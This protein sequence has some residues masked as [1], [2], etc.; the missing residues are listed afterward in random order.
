[1]EE[2]S[3]QGRGINKGGGD[4]TLYKRWGALTGRRRRWMKWAQQDEKEW[5]RIITWQQH[6][7]GDWTFLPTACGAVL[8]SNFDSGNNITWSCSAA[9]ALGCV[10]ACTCGK[11]Q[12]CRGFLLDHKLQTVAHSTPYRVA[13]VVVTRIS[14][15][16]TAV[17]PSVCCIGP[18]TASPSH[19]GPSTHES[20]RSLTGTLLLEPLSTK[21]S[22]S[23]LVDLFFFFF[24]GGGGAVTHKW[25]WCVIIPSLCQIQERCLSFSRCI[26]DSV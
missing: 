15:T 20:C 17:G 4:D 22:C 7:S 5:M 13:A 3:M 8:P 2:Q 26:T 11:Q 6:F 14:V 19:A 24:L 16:T 9:A 23:P 25:Q 10:A 21:P 1:M 12:S 18:Q